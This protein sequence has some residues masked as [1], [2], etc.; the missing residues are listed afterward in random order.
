MVTLKKERKIP[1]RKINMFSVI[2]KNQKDALK[3]FLE[4]ACNGSIRGE[5]YPPLR[6]KAEPRYDHDGS[7]NADKSGN[8]TN[9]TGGRKTAK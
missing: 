5:N 8:V 1:N 2:N 9:T 7:M 3:V 4:F 6:L